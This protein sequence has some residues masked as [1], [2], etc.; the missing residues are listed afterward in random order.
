[1][2]SL[3]Q[4]WFSNWLLPVDF[5]FVV[6]SNPGI[7]SDKFL[8]NVSWPSTG[9]KILKP[10]R[11]GL[12]NKVSYFVIFLYDPLNNI[13]YDELHI[14]CDITPCSSLKI[15]S[16][17]GSET[18]ESE[19]DM[20]ILNKVRKWAGRWFQMWILLLHDVACLKMSASIHKWHFTFEQRKRK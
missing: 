19:S 2:D 6:I 7:G 13:E 14:F 15:N 20:K 3:F 11:I 9:P 5:L 12:F 10:Q 16:R 18:T 17:W 8:Y 1:M 4:E